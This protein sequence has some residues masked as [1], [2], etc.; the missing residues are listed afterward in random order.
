[1]EEMQNQQ[2]QQAP[3]EPQIRENFIN[4]RIIIIVAIVIVLL[5]IGLDIWIL[6]GGLYK[7][8]PNMPYGNDIM[9]VIL[10]I[11][12]QAPQDT[13]SAINN[14]LNSVNVESV[15][16]SFNEIDVDLNNL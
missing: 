7:I 9:P 4:K 10:K 16:N 8:D 13:T 14:D 1:M 6:K 11:Q 12:K 5:L 3:Q 2:N 15:D